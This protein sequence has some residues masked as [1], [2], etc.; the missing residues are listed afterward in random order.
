[1]AIAEMERGI[2]ELGLIGIE[3]SSNAN[4][5]TLDDLEIQRFLEAAAKMDVPILVHPWAKAGEERMPKR[6]FMY[7]IGMPSETA[8]AA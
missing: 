5:K 8:L 6:N 7:S 2:K 3:I 1:M 4:G